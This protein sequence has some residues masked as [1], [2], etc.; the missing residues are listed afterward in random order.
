[1]KLVVGYIF[2]RKGLIAAKNETTDNVISKLDNLFGKP[3]LF[4]NKLSKKYENSY[5]PSFG[6]R[7][8][9]QRLHGL[10]LSQ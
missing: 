3:S 4:K 5:E 8:S 7:L 1:M 2:N 9:L 6:F 10:E